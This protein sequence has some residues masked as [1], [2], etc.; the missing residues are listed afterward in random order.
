MTDEDG[1]VKSIS[2]FIYDVKYVRLQRDSMMKIMVLR[3]Y[4]VCGFLERRRGV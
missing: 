2:S 3:M 4:R 1:S